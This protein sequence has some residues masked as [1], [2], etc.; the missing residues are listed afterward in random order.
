M[1][2]VVYK[3]TF[4]RCDSIYNGKTDRPL[5]VR[6]REHIGISYFTFQKTKP[7]NES[8]INHH[9]LN[10]DNFPSFEEFTILTSGNNKFVLEIKESLLIK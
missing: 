8:A 2:G 1:S 5:Q 4:G 9:L 6:C 10:C 7:S 3:Y